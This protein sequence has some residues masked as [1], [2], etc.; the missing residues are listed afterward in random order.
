MGKYDPSKMN[1]VRAEA[2]RNQRLA[3][4]L[5]YALENFK[6]V[7][8]FDDNE[9]WALFAANKRKEYLETASIF[10]AL[11][12]SASFAVNDPDY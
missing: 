10:S 12:E 11:S 3:D 6:Y 9:N 7:S 1:A 2:E 5:G 8:G 4:E